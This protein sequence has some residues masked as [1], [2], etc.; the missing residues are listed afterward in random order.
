LGGIE[1]GGAHR[2]VARPSR[3]ALLPNLVGNGGIN[4]RA[5]TGHPPLNT[6]VSSTPTNPRLP[7][8]LSILIR[9]KSVNDSGLLAGDEKVASLARH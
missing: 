6:A 2:S 3:T 7:N 4:I 1:G 8:D 5:I 9:I